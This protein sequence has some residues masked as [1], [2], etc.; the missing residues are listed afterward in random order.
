MTEEDKKLLLKDLCGRLPYNVKCQIDFGKPC[1]TAYVPDDYERYAEDTVICI[2]PETLEIG[3][4][5]EDCACD[6]LDIKP[7]LRS[8]SSMTE[9]EKKTYHKKNQTSRLNALE[10]PIEQHLFRTQEALDWL[11]AHYF[12]YRGLIKKGLALEAP[13][14]MYNKR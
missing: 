12:D 7:Y 2:W 14:K 3:V 11:N 9:E 1:R 4:N 5:N 10:T 8:M 6:I 13:E